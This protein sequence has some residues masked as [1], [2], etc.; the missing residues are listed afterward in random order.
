MKKID[1]MGKLANLAEAASLFSY[2]N[3]T[4]WRKIEKK[5]N[6]GLNNDH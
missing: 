1:D 5:I 6:N 2:E 3:K 4:F